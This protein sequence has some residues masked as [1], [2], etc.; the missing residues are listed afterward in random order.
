MTYNDPNNRARAN[1]RW[2]TGTIALV[3][4]VGI[5]ILGG[6]VYGLSNRGMSTAS[7]TGTTPTTTGAGIA[8]SPLNS[9][10]PVATAPPSTTPAP[11]IPAGSGT[12]KP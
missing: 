2:G 11:Q 8:K 6:R 5:L 9:T 4:N 10:S 3:A 7:N 1:D 12:Q